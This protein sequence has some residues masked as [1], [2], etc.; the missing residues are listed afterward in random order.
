MIVGRESHLRVLQDALAQA[1]RG[2]ASVT[3]LHGDAGIGKSALLTHAVGCGDGLV[4]L[5]ASGHEAESDLP[6]AGLHQLLAP[7]TRAIGSLPEPQRHALSRALALESGPPGDQMITASAVLRL[8]TEQAET[9]PVVV[10]ADDF[11][12]LDQSTRQVLIF[13]ARRIE[14]DAVAMLLAQR[15]TVADDLRTVGTPL[16]VGQLPRD[17]SRELLRLT[18]PDLSAVVANKIVDRAAGL[19][20]ALVEIPAE[21]SAGQRAASEP[22][23][24]KF[25]VG[26]FIQRLYRSRLDRLDDAARLALLIA[27]YEDLDP[28]SLLRALARAGLDLSALDGPERHRLVRVEDGRCRFIHPTVRGAVQVSATSYE[29]GRAHEALAACFAADPPRYALYVQGCTSVA[30]EDVVAALEAAARQAQDQ[31]GFI[32]AAIAWEDRKSVV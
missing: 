16:L 28:E 22:L 15:G 8:L 12:W 21:L 10:V 6:Y 26:E 3:V 23:P 13:V 24:S 20:L 7:L 2:V 30:D 32:E 29:V 9:R 18:Y 14:A 19:P 27:S 31:G 11:Q 4:I 17:E 5:S 25:P 1:R